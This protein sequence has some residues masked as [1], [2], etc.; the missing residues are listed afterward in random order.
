MKQHNEILDRMHELGYF[1]VRRA[2]WYA[3]SPKTKP[4]PTEVKMIVLHH[5]AAPSVADYLSKSAEGRKLIVRSFQRYHQD[6]KGWADIGYHFVIGPDGVIFEGRPF[7][8]VGAHCGLA[9][10]GAKSVFGNT[11]TVAIALIGDYDQDEP[12]KEALESYV[13]L[14]AAMNAVAGEVLP[15]RGHFECATKPP[16]T[17]PGEKLA[18]VISPAMRAA[19]TKAFS[20]RK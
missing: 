16:K 12:T 20:Y 18:R 14:T 10:K 9:P 1:I 19:W 2:D 17:C 7:G 5:T 11:G 3:A 4:V 6:E 13:S 8:Y 15:I